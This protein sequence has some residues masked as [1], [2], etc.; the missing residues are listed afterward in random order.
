M[1]ALNLNFLTIVV[2]E[3]DSA[4]ASPRKLTD[5]YIHSDAPVGGSKG[6]GKSRFSDKTSVPGT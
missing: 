3:H 5:S 4:R 1:I 2:L 6:F